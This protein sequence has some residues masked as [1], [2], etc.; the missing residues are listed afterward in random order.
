MLV[1]HYRISSHYHLVRPFMTLIVLL[2]RQANSHHGPA[3]YPDPYNLLSVGCDRLSEILTHSIGGRRLITSNLRSFH[4]PPRSTQA[5]PSQALY[6]DRPTD[7]HVNCD[8]LGN[9]PD[10]SRVMPLSL[11]WQEAVNLASA[12]SRYDRWILRAG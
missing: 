5:R 11:S 12:K 2:P 7:V 6:C 10:A 9:R 8:S 4:S 1:G 3:C